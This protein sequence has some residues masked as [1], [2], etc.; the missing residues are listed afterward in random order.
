MSTRSSDTKIPRVLG[1]AFLIQAVASA[2]WFFLLQQLM[3]EGNIVASMTNIA[4]NAVQMR[5]IVVLGL[6]TA[7]GVAILGC[8]LYVVLKNQNGTL[9]IVALVLYLLEAATLAASRIEAYSLLRI[10]QESVAAG[11]PEYLQVL[12]RLFYDSADFGD[13][14]HMLPFALGALF[15][16]YLFFKSGY[17]PR[18]LALWGLVA[19][20]LAVVGTLFVLLGFDVPMA[21]FMISLPFELTIGIWLL[22]KGIRDIDLHAQM[23]S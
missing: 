12:G 19:V 9:A 18:L 1:I 5:A 13:W 20:A 11:H 3:V 21:V 8:L 4:N 14:M 7:M 2:A 23:Q 15:F 22:V 16:Y 6:I 17:I 10:S